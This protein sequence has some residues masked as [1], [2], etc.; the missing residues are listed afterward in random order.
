MKILNIIEA[1]YRGTIEEQDDTILW[2][3]T[4]MKGAGGDFTVLVRGNAINHCVTSQD[5]SGLS[6]G[7]WEQMQ[8]PRLASDTA[9]LIDK[10]VEVHYVAEDAA[11]RGLHPSDMVS[12]VK[13]I[14][15]DKVAELCNAHDQVWHW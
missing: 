7:G 4:I 9:N 1:A 8:P 2:L 13:P 12:G 15:R 6:F 10:G 11:E 14:S 3:T 5:C